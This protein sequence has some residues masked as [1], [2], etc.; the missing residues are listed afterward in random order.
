M[1]VGVGVAGMIACCW[2]KRLLTCMLWRSIRLV[3]LNPIP[4]FHSTSLLRSYSDCWLVP[5]AVWLSALLH[6]DRV[7]DTV[8]QQRRSP[9]LKNED[10]EKANAKTRTIYI[11]SENAGL[12]PVYLVYRWSHSTMLYGYERSTPILEMSRSFLRGAI[13]V[14]H[15]SEHWIFSVCCVWMNLFWFC[16][17]PV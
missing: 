17:S 13:I 7:V 14:G 2:I 6:Q 10:R 11:L 9:Q 16:S 3:C 8:V 1:S 12:I 5:T 15:G 4:S